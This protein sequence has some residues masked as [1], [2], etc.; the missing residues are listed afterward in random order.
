MQW[1]GPEAI[2]SSYCSI[3]MKERWGVQ[4]RASKGKNDIG[5]GVNFQAQGIGLLESASHLRT[6]FC[7]FCYPASGRLWFLVRKIFIFL[8]WLYLNMLRMDSAHATPLLQTLIYLSNFSWNICPQV[9][10][11]KLSQP[12]LRSGALLWVL[13]LFHHKPDR[14]ILKWLTCLL[15]TVGPMGVGPWFIYFTILVT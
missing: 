13:I 9:A 12:W 11:T 4:E 6:S 14:I 2:L 8:L 7:R 1:A 3:K 5:L 15:Y 10:P